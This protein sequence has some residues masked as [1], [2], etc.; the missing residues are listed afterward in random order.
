MKVTAGKLKIVDFASNT[1]TTGAPTGNV[2]RK[3]WMDK[4]RKT[5]RIHLVKVNS[6][7]ALLFTKCNCFRFSC[8]P[9]SAA[10]VTL[11]DHQAIARA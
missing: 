10:Y 2:N 9:R 5:S 4:K 7:Y 3:Y 8:P 1:T 11:N 6:V